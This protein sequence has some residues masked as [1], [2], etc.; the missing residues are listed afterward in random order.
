MADLKQVT[1]TLGA[2]VFLMCE[3]GIII[4]PIVLGRYGR[5]GI[6]YVMGSHGAAKAQ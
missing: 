2:L 3:V 6:I 1:L 4:V 5:N